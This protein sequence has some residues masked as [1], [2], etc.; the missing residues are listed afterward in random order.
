[1]PFDV[2]FNLGRP[3]PHDRIGDPSQLDFELSDGP[4]ERVLTFGA[5]MQHASSRA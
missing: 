3:S 2:G 1:V 4:R 5:G